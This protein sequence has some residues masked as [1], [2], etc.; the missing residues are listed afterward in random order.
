MQP[1]TGEGAGVGARRVFATSFTRGSHSSRLSFIL[2]PAKAA[3]RKFF[4]L[5]GRGKVDITKK[6]QPVE[7]TESQTS[8]DLLKAEQKA[9]VAAQ[10]SQGRYRK[11]NSLER[12]A[13][14]QQGAGAG[15]STSTSASASAM[16][17][18]S[19]PPPPPPPPP[20]RVPSAR[21]F[22]AGVPLGTEAGMLLRASFIRGM[23][24][25]DMAVM[26]GI[27]RDFG[28]AAVMWRAEEGGALT[29]V[30]REVLRRGLF[31]LLGRNLFLAGNASQQ[32]QAP[33]AQQYHQGPELMAIDLGWCADA[34]QQ[35]RDVLY[36]PEVSVGQVTMMRTMIA[37]L[38]PASE[39][40]N[41]AAF[42]GG[43]FGLS[44]SSPAMLQQDIN[45]VEKSRSRAEQKL[46]QARA[47]LGGGA[48]DIAALETVLGSCERTMTQLTEQ[49][50]GLEASCRADGMQNMDQLCTGAFAAGMRCTMQRLFAWHEEALRCVAHVPR[51]GELLRSPEEMVELIHRP[52]ISLA[53]T[54]VR[55]QLG[56]SASA[57]ARA[58]AVATEVIRREDVIRWTLAESLLAGS[59]NTEAA[60]RA[61][62]E[63]RFVQG[64]SAGQRRAMMEHLIFNHHGEGTR[65]QR[66]ELVMVARVSGLLN[67][68][69]MRGEA[70][71]RTLRMCRDPSIY[72]AVAEDDEEDTQL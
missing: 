22:F 66:E 2:R 42:L 48:D 64:L 58:E 35:S 69:N 26:P 11:R 57:D 70:F 30:Q 18:P 1:Q 56:A 14:A 65:E 47:G 17:S 49:M 61:F 6:S 9:H 16:P 32:L 55:D 71:V 19:A 39:T 10:K 41:R 23:A 15:A 24:A 40:N 4:K 5:T 13:E 38:T 27:L 62:Y 31:L 63:S 54:T 68:R 25:E 8:L 29:Q 12:Q 45:S 3:V 72:F 60:N 7:R 52:L 67:G 37:S 59:P 34:L 50:N 33:D 28:Q 20:G 36:Q 51:Y 43:V 44:D 21:G 53:E 46:A